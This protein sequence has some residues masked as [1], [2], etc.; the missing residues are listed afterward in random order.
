MKVLLLMRAHLLTT[1]AKL[2]GSGGAKTIVADNLRK[3]FA[4]RLLSR[5]S[6]INDVQHLGELHCEYGLSA[7][8]TRTHA[9]HGGAASLLTDTVVRSIN[10]SHHR[11]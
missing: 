5:G 6:A 10:S 4:T 9:E 2:L 8:A 3:T 1:L 11:R 7:M